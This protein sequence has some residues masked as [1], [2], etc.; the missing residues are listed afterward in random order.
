MDRKLLNKVMKKLASSNVVKKTSEESTS[1]SLSTHK[2]SE[3]EQI[4]QKMEQ[5]LLNRYHFR[6][7]VLTEQTEY[8]KKG[9]GTP[10]YKVISQRTLNS[11]C[12]EARARHINCWDK[13]V[14]RFVN[15]EQMPDYHPL[16]SYMDALPE[17]D[18]KDRVTPL[19]QRISAKSF[20][21]NSFH[22]WLL[23]VT[24]QW[25]GRMARCANAVAPM[26]VSSEQGRCKSTF[27]ELLMPDSL[28]DYYT[29]SFELTGQ[30]GC[31][32]KLA[33]FGL[34]NL[35]EYDRLPPQKLPLLK[36]LMQMKKLDFR[37]SHRSS[38]SHLPRMASFI[39]TS[40]RK[41]LLTDPS[42][43]RRYFFAEVKE[44]IDCSP[45]EH[46]QLFA[47][48]KA[49]LDEG[50]RYWFSAE[51]EAELKLRNQAYY[52]LPTETE[53]VFHYFRLPEKDEDF[54]LYSAVALFNFLLKRYPAA[55]RG[56]TVNKMGRIMNS[57]GAERMH[58][59]TGNMYK[60]V[61]LAG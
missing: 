7:N 59:T 37:K 27:C 29:D 32:Q 31:E 12:L 44:K 55:M 39:G 8:S 47:Q 38:Y 26:L 4:Q 34:I 40:N 16:L 41:A 30:A 25:S 33:F 57:I 60:L 21:V 15:S 58:T 53:M 22:R 1:S 42:G 51:E 28:K 10:I 5:Y 24:A 50:K 9:N 11:L 3:T 45:L 6:F 48:L 36:N 35:D 61:P 54:K 52:A 20:W 43:S 17:W 2:D 56:M 23:G 13:D 14:S 19:A 18:G 49:E 46:K